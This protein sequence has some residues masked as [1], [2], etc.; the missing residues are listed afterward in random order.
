VCEMVIFGAGWE[1][2]VSKVGRPRNE[3][4][5]TGRAVQTN[6]CAECRS[7]VRKCAHRLW[8]TI[9]TFHDGRKPASKR[10]EPYKAGMSRAMAN[11][12]TA[13]WVGEYLKA[14]TTGNK[15]VNAAERTAMEK[16]L[17]VWDDERVQVQKLTDTASNLS[18]YN[19]HIG[20]L[21][22]WK[23]VRAWTKDMM[24]ALSTGLKAKVARE[25]I[26]GKTAINIWSTATQICDDASEHEDD[27][28]KCR[29][30]DPSYKVRGPARGIEKKKQFLRPVELLQ[31]VRCK[32]VPLLWRIVVAVGVYTYLRDGELR[33]LTCGDVQIE[34]QVISITKAWIRRRKNRPGHI[35][36]PK[37]KEPRE[38]MIE[39][40]LMPL[41]EALKAGRPDD[42]L[43]FPKFPST[44]GM[45]KGLKR[46]MR[47]AGLTRN[48]LLN[49]TPTTLPMTWHDARA[50]GI[51]WRCVREDPKFEI[52][53]HAGHKDFTTTEIYIHLA[54][55]IRR[56]F[57]ETFPTLPAELLERAG[58]VFLDHEADHSSGAQKQSARNLSTSGT[59]TSGADGTRTRGLRRDRPA[60]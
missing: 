4:L 16:W 54:G 59:L 58:S 32:D 27:A 56:G 9:L 18:H 37:G 52:Q 20:P 10:L 21:T 13:Y 14:D 19:E 5:V 6:P 2:R 39:P 1:T 11:E 60:L 25:E 30:D 53:Y 7:A 46:W 29:D 47:R 36:P 50:T 51:T 41:L 12:K 45:S 55:V 43:L 33:V 8:Q 49:E 15:V 42:E 57:G 26:A 28:I 23:H 40:T 17:K 44:N 24:R 22:N 31:F 35:G 48:E 38:V 3:A 34:N